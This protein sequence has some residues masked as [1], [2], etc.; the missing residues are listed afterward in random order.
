MKKEVI[1]EVDPPASAFVA[2]EVNAS[3]LPLLEEASDNY[4]AEKGQFSLTF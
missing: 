4:E 1:L 2:V 3:P